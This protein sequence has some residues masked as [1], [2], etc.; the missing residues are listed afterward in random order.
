MVYV[1]AQFLN[2]ELSFLHK[3]DNRKYYLYNTNE[4]EYLYKVRKL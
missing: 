3:I 4:I 2:I 1:E